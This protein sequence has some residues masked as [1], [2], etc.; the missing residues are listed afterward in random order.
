MSSLRK[1]SL[2]ALAIGL[3]LVCCV[4]WG[5]QQ[6][7]VK[8]T[9]PHM[10]PVMQAALRFA[11]ATVLLWAW[12]RWRGIAL[13]AR[14]DTLRVGVLAGSLFA[15][16]FVCLYIGLAHSSASWRWCCHGLCPAKRC[17]HCSGS[18]WPALL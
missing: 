5:A 17:A 15:M 16:E 1:P 13:F 3:L 18:A 2:D 12:C 4:F 11:G 14:D 6:V 10:P 7:L 9:L 8:A